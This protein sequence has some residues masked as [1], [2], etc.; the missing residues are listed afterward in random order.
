G[1][2]GGH[3]ARVGAVHDRLA[4][5]LRA[6]RA[7]ARPR[8]CD[9]DGCEGGQRLPAAAL[10]VRRPPSRWIARRLLI[11]GA[12]QVAAGLLAASARLGADAAVLMHG[13]VLTAGVT[14]RPAGRGTGLEH[15]TRQV[16]VV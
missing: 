14:A 13:G 1:G 7:R 12:D 10:L 3:R 8:A 9:Q 16:A 11:E 2:R 4:D 5:R 15:G 6:P